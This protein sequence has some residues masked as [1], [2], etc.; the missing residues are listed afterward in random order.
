M[1][2]TSDFIFVVVGGK[3]I[4]D[5]VSALLK[6]LIV[7]YGLGKTIRLEGSVPSRDIPAYYAAADLFIMPSEEEGFGIVLLEAMAAGVPFVT[8]DEGKL[9]TS[10]SN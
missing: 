3:G 5:D 6:S 10:L 9:G 8:T 4:G 7:R 2:G 1:K